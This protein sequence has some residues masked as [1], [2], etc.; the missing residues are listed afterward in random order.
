MSKRKNRK[1]PTQ[2]FRPREI[3]ETVA[4]I[5]RIKA[6]PLRERIRLLAGARSSPRIRALLRAAMIELQRLERR[7]CSAPI[8]DATADA[9]QPFLVKGLKRAR[10]KVRIGEDAIPTRRLTPAPARKSEDRYDLMS[11]AAA[12]FCMDPP[13]ITGIQMQR[14]QAIR[15]RLEPRRLKAARIK[16]E[17]SEK[18]D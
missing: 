1:P 5:K 7:A 12:L 15:G 11:H 6:L 3:E 14:L 10:G 8:I 4:L 2:Q 13:S 16:R 9:G 18:R 17:N